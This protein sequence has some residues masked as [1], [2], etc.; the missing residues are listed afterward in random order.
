LRAV[1]DRVEAMSAEV[2]ENLRD[3]L[4]REMGEFHLHVVEAG[5]R[6]KR[7]GEE[8]LQV[9]QHALAEECE[10]HRRELERLQATGA[11]ESSRLRAEV[12]E[13]D[14]RIAKL[15]ESARELES[16]LDV[17]LSKLAS[18]TVS[19]VR[20]QLENTVDVILEEL[21]KRSSQQLKEQVDEAGVRLGVMQKGIE[22]AVAESMQVHAAGRLEEFEKTLDEL[23]R[24]SVDR[25]RGA[26]AGGLNSLA[27]S[28]GERFRLD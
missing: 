18:N 11:S 21:G 22:N 1:E 15:Y 5:N 2:V 17:R 14:G 20:T 27:R 19:S 23:A 24:K 10:T 12:A 3:H 28:L 8:L 6:L 26:L 4:R 13:L 25:C 16:G 9:Q 7:L